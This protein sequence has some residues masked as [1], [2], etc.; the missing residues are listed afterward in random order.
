M[1]CYFVVE[2]GHRVSHFRSHFKPM[3]AVFMF[4]RWPFR[5]PLEEFLKNSNPLQSYSYFSKL[6]PSK[7]LQHSARTCA[8]SVLS[9]TCEFFKI[10]IGNFG[11]CQLPLNTK[12]MTFWNRFF[13][14]RRNLARLWRNLLTFL[15][16]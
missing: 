14:N 8:A 2:M 15:I 4:K 13:C 5:I 1:C 6:G 11:Y 16:Y 9:P 12:K 10:Q 7:P 3:K